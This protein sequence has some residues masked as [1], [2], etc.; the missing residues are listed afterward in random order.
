MKQTLPALALIAVSLALPGSATQ[1][2]PRQPIHPWIVDYGATSC[3]ASRTYGSAEAPLVL[4]FRP[5]PKGQAIHLLL[6]RP[7]KI[8]APEQLPVTVTL[9]TKPLET[10]L[11]RHAAADRKTEILRMSFNRAELDRLGDAGRVR[12]KSPRVI[13][14][15]FTVPGMKPVLKALDTCAADLQQHW[16]IGEAA[17]ARLT[18]KA[19]SLKPLASYFSSGDYPDMA[20]TRNMTGRTEVLLLVDE[21]GALKDCSVESTSGIA[22]LDA[23][24]CQVLRVRA[25]FRPATDAVGKPAKSVIVSAIRWKMAG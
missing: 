16:N 21:Q 20:F 15:E 18:S 10:T 9:G 25:K 3:S 11:L 1:A 17:E 4:A 23:M 6:A 13:D 14:E 24:S 7:S 2:A 19:A 22:S 5:S 12:V 8:S